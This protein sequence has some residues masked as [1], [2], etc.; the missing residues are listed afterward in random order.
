LRD[1]VQSELEPFSGASLS[2]NWS[3]EKYFEL[4]N[5]ITTP[6]ETSIAADI[7]FLL[8]AAAWIACNCISRNF[9]W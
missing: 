4:T 6:I 5:D 8:I 9:W 2:Y 7:F 1:S 3:Y